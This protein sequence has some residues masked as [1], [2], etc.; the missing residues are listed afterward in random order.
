MVKA[1]LR[2]EP[3]A[4]FGVIASADSNIAYDSSGRHLLSPAL[5]KIG[6]WH[7]RQGL[8]T[9]TLTPST[10]SGGLSL[11]VT[12][13]ASSPSSLVM[14]FESRLCSLEFVI[15]LNGFLVALQIAGGYWDGSIRIWDSDKGACETTLNG[16]KGAVT[17]LRYN[18][19]GSLLASGSKD[20]DVILWDVVG[21]TGLFRLRGHREQVWFSYLWIRSCLARLFSKHLIEEGKRDK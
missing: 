11:T 12:S 4:S 15:I 16:H 14:N 5:E 10:A 9:K 19:A 21:E 17:A 13:I 7:V 6:V 20:N 1:Y 18:K 3:A 2:Y 8:C